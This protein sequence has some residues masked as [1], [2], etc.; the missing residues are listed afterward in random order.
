MIS[1]ENLGRFIGEA[2]VN[3][4]GICYYPGRF[5]PPHRGHFNVV[6][7]LRSEPY[8]GRIVVII[9][10]KEV[11]GIT[12]KESEFIWHQFLRAEHI[13]DVEIKIAT[14]ESPITDI[15]S[16]VDHDQSTDP[17]Y[18][19]GGVDEVDDQG[20]LQALQRTFGESRIKPLP[21]A[22]KEGEVTA[23]NIRNLLTKKAPDAVKRKEFYATLPK[24]T[25]D[26]GEAGEIYDML[27]KTVSKSEK[28]E[29]KENFEP[30][31]EQ[32]RIALPDV[33]SSVQALKS[34]LNMQGYD[35]ITVDSQST[36]LT[37]QRFME[38]CCNMLGIEIIPQV[39]IITDPSYSRKECSFGGY[40]PV[41]KCIYTVVFNRNTA[42]I[43]RT[44]AHELVHHRQNEVG[45]ISG[46][47]GDT[48][49]DIENEANAVAGMI[50]R[51]YGK[52]NPEIFEH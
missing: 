49:S 21:M 15:M 1:I 26:K 22:E 23:P 24:S 45:G 31:V 20:Y 27:M 50:M 35:L 29:I 19:V 12:A 48:G 14:S 2:I 41:N 5:K 47:D 30:T 9:S 8:I 11:D 40:D 44:L 6:K 43:L 28:E 18:V 39:H 37:I 16:D 3:E 17:I 46:A 10:P 4:K 25:V 7:D 13:P 36:T 32:V 34:V 38:W 42:D 51:E 33:Y 52:R